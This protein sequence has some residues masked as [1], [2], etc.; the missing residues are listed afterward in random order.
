M[1]VEQVEPSLLPKA[2]TDMS[3]G[4]MMV[5]SDPADKINHLP[6]SRQILAPDA[7]DRSQENPDNAVFNQVVGM[8]QHAKREVVIANAY[9]LPG[10]SFVQLLENTVKPGVHVT[11]VTNSLESNDVPFV[12]SYYGSYRQRL[13]ASGV[14]WYELRGF[15][16]P[17]SVEGNVWKNQFYSDGKLAR[18]ALHTKAMAVDGSNAYVGSMNFDP[19]SIVWNTEMGVFYQNQGFA[20][21]IRNL[22]MNATQP[23][24]SYA[25]K[26]NEHGQLTWPAAPNPSNYDLRHNATRPE[27]VEPGSNRRKFIRWFAKIVPETYM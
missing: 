3:W 16:N 13:I 23:A 27:T 20:E 1:A 18:L 8:I 4:E 26:L 17:Q 21:Q 22:I 19:R 9:I 14:E 12:M 24:Y 5:V 15:P 25:V 2:L 10:E 6:K 11:V 7:H